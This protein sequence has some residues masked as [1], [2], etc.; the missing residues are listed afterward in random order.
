MWRDWWRRRH[1]P[2]V[3][4]AVW[5]VVGGL[6]FLALVRMSVPICPEC[7]CVTWCDRFGSFWACMVAGC[8]NCP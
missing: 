5:G 6:A 7:A 1:E 8:C 3:A 2:R 4:G